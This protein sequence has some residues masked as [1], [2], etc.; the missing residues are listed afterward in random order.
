MGGNYCK[1]H[2]ISSIWCHRSAALPVFKSGGAIW[3][4]SF[5]ARAMVC[6]INWALWST[7]P[8]RTTVL[9]IKCSRQLCC[10]HD[11]DLQTV[12]LNN[13]SWSDTAIEASFGFTKKNA[14]LRLTMESRCRLKRSSAYPGPGSKYAMSELCVICISF[15]TRSK[16]TKPVYRIQWSTAVAENCVPIR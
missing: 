14:V 1:F 6:A 12:M 7:V 15:Y 2:P 8:E 3:P 4:S 10:F 9:R 5:R 16:Q 13:I 11:E